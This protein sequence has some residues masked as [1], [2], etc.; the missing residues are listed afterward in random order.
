MEK[1][2]NDVIRK[3]FNIFDKLEINPEDFVKHL[4]EDDYIDPNDFKRAFFEY[5]INRA[6]LGKYI[7]ESKDL[8]D[9]DIDKYDGGQMINCDD[10]FKKTIIY[11]IAKNPEKY[12]YIVETFTDNIKQAFADDEHFTGGANDKLVD[13]LYF[14]WSM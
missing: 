7:E 11:A 14:Y 5:L 4:D 1:Y 13:K 9:F 6:H 2:K 8:D 10:L 3:L 12:N